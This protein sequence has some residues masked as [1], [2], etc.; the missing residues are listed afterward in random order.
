MDRKSKNSGEAIPRAS[1]TVDVSRISL[2]DDDGVDV[3]DQLEDIASRYSL[4]LH[5]LV[6]LSNARPGRGFQPVTGYVMVLDPKAPILDGIF[7][8]NKL[9]KGRV[10]APLIDVK[11]SVAV[12]A[13]TSA[14]LDASKLFEA[15]EKKIPYEELHT[16][17]ERAYKIAFDKT[18][19]EASARPSHVDALRASNAPCAVPTFSIMKKAFGFDIPH[20]VF[21]DHA[22]IYSPDGVS[23][24]EERLKKA[25]ERG[26]TV[27][28]FFINPD[29]Q[30]YYRTQLLWRSLVVHTMRSFIIDAIMGA[31]AVKNLDLHN[32]ELTD[33]RSGDVHQVTN[34]I[35]DNAEGEVVY[36]SNAVKASV[37]E[38]ALITSGPFGMALWVNRQSQTIGKLQSAGIESAVPYALGS[39]QPRAYALEEIV[40]ALENESD[41]A[42]P[43]H[44]RAPQDTTV[45]NV[46][47]VVD[48]VPWMTNETQGR[49]VI[50]SATLILPKTHSGVRVA[51]PDLNAHYREG[52][53]SAKSWQDLLECGVERDI[54]LNEPFQPVVT[55][56]L[57][58]NVIDTLELWKAKMKMQIQSSSSK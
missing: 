49:I 56:T 5:K 58:P 25:L 47:K 45:S 42:L 7:D 4:H 20:L 48:H 53:E 15:I 14:G 40:I 13:M 57:V 34:L 16:L 21:E 17:L 6:A 22:N 52:L 35:Y 55:V 39:V 26:D 9:F 54:E 10:I 3:R 32:L 46:V 31:Q 43:A 38:G 50:G 23:V 30:R 1:I 8:V 41:Q 2:K 18:N 11:N 36:Y 28:D 37:E 24:I 27:N 19:A 44:I 33:Q 51:I 29:M 12:I